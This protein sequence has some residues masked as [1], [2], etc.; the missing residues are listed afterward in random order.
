MT[1]YD[2]M[3]S[4]HGLLVVFNGLR[5]FLLGCGPSLC[6]LIISLWFFNFRRC[7]VQHVRFFF[8]WLLGCFCW[9]ILWEWHCENIL[10]VIYDKLTLVTVTVFRVVIWMTHFS[11]YH[12]LIYFSLYF[13]IYCDGSR[14]SLALCCILPRS[15]L[16]RLW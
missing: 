12:D 14:P 5:G 2:P 11:R 4:L 7:M 13:Y 10:L 3:L 8:F 6:Y 9:N 16:V 1:C 15:L